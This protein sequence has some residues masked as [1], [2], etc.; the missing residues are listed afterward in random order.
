MRGAQLGETWGD[1]DDE[2][3]LHC[4]CAGEFMIVWVARVTKQNAIKLIEQK[5]QGKQWILTLVIK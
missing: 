5:I 1:L 3:I 2:S 4:D